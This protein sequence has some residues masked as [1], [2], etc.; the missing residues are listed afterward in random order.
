GSRYYFR[1]TASTPRG[2]IIAIDVTKP[3]RE[4]WKVIVPEQKD[5]LQDARMAGGMLALA[6]LKDAYSAARIHKLDGTFL[7]DVSLPGI[8]SVTWSPARS[9]DTELFYSYT[10]FTAPAAIYRYDL[11]TG[12]STL[13]RQSK[14]NFDP[15]AYETRQIFYNSKDG[16]RIP[17]FL[18]YKKGLA[19]NGA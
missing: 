15:A 7:R 11:K 6:Y 12:A 17:M 2:R 5:T 19:Q 18:V 3:E 1:T 9:A 13:V 14:V 10:S 8:G 16:T 4:N